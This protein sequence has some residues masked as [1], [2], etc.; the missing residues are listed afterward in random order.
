MSKRMANGSRFKV[1]RDQL[2]DL[3]EHDDPDVALAATVV[4]RQRYGEDPPG[5][6][7][8][9]PAD[10]P[11]PDDADGPT[12]NFCPGCGREL[13]GDESFCPECGDELSP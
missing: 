10:A 9:E 7:G 6:G 4:Y 3:A 2:A 8:P 13:E 1:S 5:A 11:G 12:M